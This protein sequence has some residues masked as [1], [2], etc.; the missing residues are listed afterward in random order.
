MKVELNGQVVF[1]DFSY[2]RFAGDG[3]LVG[4]T[5]TCLITEK[6]TRKVLYRGRS[7]CSARDQFCKD[8]GRKY[9]LSRAVKSM[10]RNTRKMIWEAYF[11]RSRTTVFK[12]QIIVLPTLAY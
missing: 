8:V 1:V 7:E 12:S 11:N 10:P 9:A 5:T 6:G 4:G 2:D 3:R